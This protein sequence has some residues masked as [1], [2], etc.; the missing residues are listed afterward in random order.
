MGLDLRRD[1]AGRSEPAQDL[2][3]V[4]EGCGVG[5]G[6]TGGDD[7]EVVADDIREDQGNGP[8]GVDDPGQT[9]SLDPGEVFPD[10]VQF[11]DSGAG[12]E[13]NLRGL[14]FRRQG[15]S[16]VRSDQQR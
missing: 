5:R 15:D 11:M 3:G 6:G 2:P 4:A 10:G 14:A 9:A 16:L 13:K 1:A 7:I 8:A 12:A